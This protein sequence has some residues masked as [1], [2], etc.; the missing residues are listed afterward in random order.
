[1]GVTVGFDA[2]TDLP[3]ELRVELL[4]HTTLPKK[5]SYKVEKYEDHDVLDGVKQ[6]D[7]LAEFA[8]RLCYQSWLRPNPKTADNEAYLGNIIEHQHFSVLEHSSATFYVTGV[9]RALLKELARHRHL[10]LSVLSQR[11]VDYS[12][13]SGVVPPGLITLEKS[14]NEEARKFGGEVQQ[15]LREHTDQAVRLY[16]WAYEGLRTHTSYTK[17]Q[18]REIAR[19]F[20]PES[21][22]TE[23]VISGNFRA[24]REFLAK[25][26]SP[27]AD[28]EIQQ[29]A[30]AISEHLVEIAPNTFQDVDEEES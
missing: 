19:A 17:K 30:K 9:S 28:R 29:L 20:L 25:R 5:L 12:N 1:M 14:R 4:A 27:H 26:D 21:V 7:E 23:F 24:W 3:N 13:A 16:Q 11:Y 15:A 8:G 6:A 18:C 22:P 10:S 2:N